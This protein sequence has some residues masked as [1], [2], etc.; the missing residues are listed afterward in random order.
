[1][2]TLEDAYAMSPQ[3]GETVM[4]ASG[5]DTRTG[6]RITFAGDWRPMAEFLG[7]IVDSQHARR[8]EVADWQVLLV[9]AGEY[10]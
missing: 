10:S 1:M 2:V 8:A 5:T 7:T 6:E 4:T 9:E 3:A